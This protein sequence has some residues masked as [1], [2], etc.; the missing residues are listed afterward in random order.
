M[1]DAKI[2]AAVKYITQEA[3]LSTNPISKLDFLLRQLDEARWSKKEL[4]RVKTACWRV[5]GAAY[6]V[7]GNLPIDQHN[8]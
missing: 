4:Y 8:R 6:G 7:D 2:N 1:D 5:L 3:I